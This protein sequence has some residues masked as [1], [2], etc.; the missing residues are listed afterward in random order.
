VVKIVRGWQ[1]KFTEDMNVPADHRTRSLIVRLGQVGSIAKGAALGLI[2]LLVIVAAIQFRP[3]K[4][5]GLDGALKA[6]AAQPYGCC[7]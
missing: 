6:L 4:S 1:K 7:C 3:D 5:V 2:G